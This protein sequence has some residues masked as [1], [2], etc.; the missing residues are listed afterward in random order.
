MN[1]KCNFLILT[2]F[3]LVFLNEFLM[4]NDVQ[5]YQQE[6]I[7]MNNFGRGRGQG[8]GLGRGLGQGRFAGPREDG[9]GPFRD[10]T[11]PNPDCP[12]KKNSE[13]VQEERDDSGRIL[14]RDGT[15]PNKDGQGPNESNLGPREDCPKK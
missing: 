14:K 3:S 12:K 11:G 7:K 8:R 6:G 9:R 5:T 1:K 4:G 10:G 2:V 13:N 15:G